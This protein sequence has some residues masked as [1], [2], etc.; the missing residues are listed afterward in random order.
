MA[1]TIK[2]PIQ[3]ADRSENE[4]NGPGI[5][6]RFIAFT[7]TQSD[8]KTMWFLLSL[9]VQGVFFLPLPAALIYYFNAPVFIIS[10]TMTLFFANIIAGM[11]GAGIKTI[12]QL[13]AAS[14]II[15]VVM[16]FICVLI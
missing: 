2:A 4:Q 14:L 13:F 16:T 9:I 8:N 5:Y 15:N 11:G 12:I 6:S 7:E 1:T 3:W 10:I